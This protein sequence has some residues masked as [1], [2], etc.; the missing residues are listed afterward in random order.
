MADS[1]DFSNEEKAQLRA[2][3]TNTE[4]NIF[5]LRNLPEVVKGALFSRYSRSTLGVRSLL[6]KE[7]I[8]G[9]E[10]SFI[11]KMGGAEEAQEQELAVKKAKQFYDRILDSY[12][13][14]SIGELGGAHVALEKVSMLAAKILEDPRIGGSPLEKSTRYIYFD[15]KVNGF[16]QYYREPILL[17]SS[18]KSLYI[19]TCDMLFDTYSSMI[20]TLT[21]MMAEVFPH[22]GKESKAAYTAALRAKVLDCLRGLLP[23]STFTNVG[24][25][26]NGRFWQSLVHR[27]Q[28]NDLSEAKDLGRGLLDELMKVIPSFVSRAELHHRHQHQMSSFHLSLQ[29]Q[30]KQMA[31]EQNISY[32]QKEVGVSLLY[33]DTTAIYKMAAT[34]LFPFTDHSW[35][36]LIDH[37]RSLPSEELIRILESAS[38]MRENRR[39]KSPRA[40][41]CSEFAFEIVV[42]FGTFRDLHRH[43]MVTQ[44]RQLLTTN[45]GY[46]FPE[47]LLDTALEK[48]YR[49]AMDQARETYNLISQDFPEEAQYVVPMAFNIR[50]FVK[51]NLRALQWLCELRSQEQ[52]HENYRKIAQSMVKKIIDFCP[53]VEYFFKFVDYKEISL[54]RLKAEKRKE[55][56]GLV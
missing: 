35:K 21:E 18:Y 36:D 37:C 2:F 4:S 47:E 40:L 55:E 39:H 45:L 11:N 42:D 8:N 16:Y 52:G 44:E 20:P 29:D 1:E 56:K 7:F 48:P 10:T 41:E 14:D 31:K 50:W 28:V 34:L 33:A 12:G 3:V 17:T 13:D 9:E 19:D 25:F 24:I 49:A 38:S 26:G 54:G 53:L 22:K 23:A 43:R 5:A 32:S 51:A 15:Q 27:L 6:L 30:L 46:F